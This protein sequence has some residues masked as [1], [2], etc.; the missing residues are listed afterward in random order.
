MLA[1]E[2]L[3]KPS[4]IYLGLLSLIFLGSLGIV[5]TL[6]IS[7]WFI[8]FLVMM[9]SLYSLYLFK[10]FGL[11]THALSILKVRRQ[12]DGR[13]LLQTKHESYLA[14]LSGQSTV[15]QILCVLCFKEIH[16]HRLLPCLVFQDSL[17]LDQYRQLI[18]ILKT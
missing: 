9:V 7:R 18:V 3:I 13:W 14:E 10:R 16:S 17:S 2:F 15:T 4:K 5:L 11:Q 1:H 6:P 8:L 12:N